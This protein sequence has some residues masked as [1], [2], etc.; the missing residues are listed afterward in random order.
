MRIFSHLF[1]QK[2]RLKYSLKFAQL[3]NGD[4]VCKSAMPDRKA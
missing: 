3:V 2:F 1:P 4:L